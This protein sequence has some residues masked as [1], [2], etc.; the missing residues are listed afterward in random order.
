MGREPGTYR[1][2]SAKLGLLD[3]DAVVAPLTGIRNDEIDRT[4]TK[5]I[6]IGIIV[7]QSKWSMLAEAEVR[8]L[9]ANK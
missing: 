9:A 5:S 6:D 7:S 8:T 2:A 4:Q 3:V 1:R